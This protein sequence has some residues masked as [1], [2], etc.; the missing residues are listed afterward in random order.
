MKHL[1]ELLEERNIIVS[2]NSVVKNNTK[3]SIPVQL[4]RGFYLVDDYT[5][6]IFVNSSDSKKAQI[7]TILHELAHIFISFSAGYGEFGSDKIDDPRESLCDEIAATLLVPED[8]LIENN[9]IY[10]NEELSNL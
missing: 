3:R 4:C 2:F 9:K 7:F 6:F 8:L 5:P 1:T 10:T